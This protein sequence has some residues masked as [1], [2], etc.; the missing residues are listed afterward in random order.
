MLVPGEEERREREPRWRHLSLLVFVFVFVFVFETE[1]EWRET[2]L[3][4][5]RICAAAL[6]DSLA[7]EATPPAPTENQQNSD[8]FSI[9]VW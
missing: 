8:L 2:A 4:G 9:Y 3:R 1:D 7:G 6:G 5:E